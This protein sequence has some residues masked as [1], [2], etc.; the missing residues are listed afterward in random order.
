M[1][2]NE[3][4]E[5]PMEFIPAGTF[6]MGNIT[7]HPDGLDREKPVHEV[8]ITRAFMM[9]RTQVTMKQ[10]RVVM[11]YNPSHFGGPDLPVEQVS[12][13]EAVEFCNRLSLL[14]GLNPCYSGSGESIQC[15]FTANGYRLPTEAEW[16]YACRAGTE[17]DF[18]TGNM[19]HSGS[20]PLDPALDRA[21]WYGGNSE[22]STHPVALKEANDFYLYDMHG[23]VREWCWDWYSGNYYA[24]SPAEDPRGPASG[25]NRVLRG[26]SWY[27]FASYC[28]SA[29]RDV[30]PPG[31]R[32]NDSV[33]FRLVRTC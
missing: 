1:P 8:T 29:D 19:T 30:A 27:D 28:R 4:Y 33:G 10:Y 15:D 18:H 13:F 25:I 17:T 3:V 26:G 11:G 31:R 9:S 14:V 5:Y 2:M 20:S 24:S 12:W 32:G 7:D 22:G 6:R 16:E 23:N 21:G